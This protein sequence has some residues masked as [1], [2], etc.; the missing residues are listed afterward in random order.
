M[1]GKRQASW[2]NEFIPSYAPQLS[3]AKSWFLFHL[4]EWQVAASCISPAPQQSPQ[5]V[6]AS[7]K[8]QFWEASFTF[9]S[10]KSLMAMTVIKSFSHA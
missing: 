2:L 1:Y 10:Q 8:S 7:A 3:G 9:G 6:A 5:V 4:E